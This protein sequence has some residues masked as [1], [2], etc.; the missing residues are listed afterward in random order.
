MLTAKANQIKPLIAGSSCDVFTLDRT[1]LVK[2]L[3][4]TAT[5][6]AQRLCED[7]VAEKSDSRYSSR[8]LTFLRHVDG[9]QLL[10]YRTAQLNLSATLHIYFCSATTTA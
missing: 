9:R 4:H 6:A 8:V 10:G 5:A 3:Q 2:C 1:K 7:N